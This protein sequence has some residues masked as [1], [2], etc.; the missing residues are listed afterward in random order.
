[1]RNKDKS[2]SEKEEVVEEEEDK[3]VHEIF[4]ILTLSND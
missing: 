2:D 4:G 3:N 1:M